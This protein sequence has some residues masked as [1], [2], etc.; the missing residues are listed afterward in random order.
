MRDA[1]SRATIASLR[2]LAGYA[3]RGLPDMPVPTRGILPHVEATDVLDLLSA[4]DDQ[5]LNYWLDGGWGVD[6]LLGEQTRPHSDLDLVVSRIE[7]DQVKALLLAR[8]YEVRRDWLPTS[9]AFR[10]SS[11]RKV[12]LHPVDTTAD[13]GGEQI[14]EDGTT[15][16]YAPP[17]DGL[18]GCRLVR[19]ASAE[20][21]LL[22]HQGYDPRRVDYDDVRRVSERFGLTPPAPFEAR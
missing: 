13:G 2:C 18:I 21:Q 1:T 5:Q 7:L 22:M 9:Q 6:C 11:G 20:D 4:L 10:D 8:G 17:V 12:D 15:W 14:L 3:T 16:H 19:C